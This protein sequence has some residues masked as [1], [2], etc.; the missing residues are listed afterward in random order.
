M[1]NGT[2]DK[3]LENWI[4]DAACSIRGAKD[5]GKQGL[6]AG[7]ADRSAKGHRI[8]QVKRQGSVVGH[9][10]GDASVGAPISDLERSCTDRCTAAV[11]IRSSQQ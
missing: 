7:P 4:W 1:P 10:A 5:A 8:A 2:P 9:I 3:S 11:R 6:L